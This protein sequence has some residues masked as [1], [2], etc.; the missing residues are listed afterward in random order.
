MRHHFAARIQIIRIVLVHDVVGDNSVHR[1][2]EHRLA[3]RRDVFR[4]HDGIR[5]VLV[6]L[7]MPVRLRRA[8]VRHRQRQPAV[9]RVQRLSVLVPRLPHMP[10]LR[11]DR[12]PDRP[13]LIVVLS[14]ETDVDLILHRQLRVRPR[15]QIQVVRL[16][17]IHR[18]FRYPVDVD[19]FDLVAVALVV[20]PFRCAGFSQRKHARCDSQNECQQQGQQH[21]GQARL[22]LFHGPPLL[23]DFP[24]SVTSSRRQRKIVVKIATSQNDPI[25]LLYSTTLIHNLQILFNIFVK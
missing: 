18:I 19:A 2:L 10:D 9:S 21:L 24:L 7:V 14:R 8:R 25:F 1:K 23:R 4:V 13:G 5:P 15:P 12:D 22:P 3:R 20:V 16:L 6:D 11:R 17:I